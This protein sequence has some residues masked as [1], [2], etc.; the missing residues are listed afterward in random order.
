M[1]SARR[2]AL[3][4]GGFGALG[5]AVSVALAD[6]GARVLR[7]SRSSRPGA[8]DVVDLGAPGA[9]AELPLLDAVVW[10]HGVNANDSVSAHDDGTL[11]SMLET[12]VELIASRAA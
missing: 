9:I 10:A 11:R 7:T 4:I 8:E 2:T 5:A 12:N 1:S 6:D 3:V